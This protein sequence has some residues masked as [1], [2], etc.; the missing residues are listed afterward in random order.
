MT[1]NIASLRFFEIYQPFRTTCLAH[2]LVGS[3]IHS[4]KLLSEPSGG[5]WNPLGHA[6]SDELCE[7]GCPLN[8]SYRGPGRNQRKPQEQDQCRLL[9]R[10]DKRDLAGAAVEAAK[11]RP[12]RPS[13]AL[14]HPWRTLEIWKLVYPVATKSHILVAG[15]LEPNT[16]PRDSLEKLAPENASRSR[17]LCRIYLA[18]SCS[19]CSGCFCRV[20]N[21][22]AGRD[23]GKAHFYA[24]RRTRA[25]Q[26]YVGKPGAGGFCY[27]QD[28]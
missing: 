28:H 16:L 8:Q 22:P 15:L 19:T 9:Q 24:A 23:L 1:L 12:V 3:L 20:F 2:S 14:P 27:Y 21:T 26:I 5:N 18:S 10:L 7:S 13:P 6:G 11:L 4:I 17:H 25:S